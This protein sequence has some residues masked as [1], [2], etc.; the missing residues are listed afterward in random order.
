M[1]TSNYWSPASCLEWEQ[2]ICN[3]ISV[4]FWICWLQWKQQVLWA[5]TAVVVRP[6]PR[7]WLMCSCCTGELSS[8][9][10]IFL[11]PLCW[12]RP[13]RTGDVV[14]TI[15]HI[16]SMLEGCVISSM[17]QQC[18]LHD[19]VVLQSQAGR[20]RQNKENFMKLVSNYLEDLQK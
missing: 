10:V 2:K 16:K 8:K 11:L 3:S 5:H 18:W 17:R 9:N 6:C 14:H 4:F 19:C 7:Q 20:E 12:L 15:Q 1:T 13:A